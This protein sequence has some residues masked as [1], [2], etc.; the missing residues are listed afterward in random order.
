MSKHYAL[1]K[2]DGSFAVIEVQDGSTVDACRAKWQEDD[3]WRLAEV[4][5]WNPA[6]APKEGARRD[7]RI[8]GG[9][10]LVET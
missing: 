8:R 1:V 10:V 9:K 2:P 7:W 6:D 5:P 3:P 4:V